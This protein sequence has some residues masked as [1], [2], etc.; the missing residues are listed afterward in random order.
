MPLAAE[1][2]AMFD[3]LAAAGPTPGVRDL[4]LPDARNMYRVARPVNPDLPIHQISDTTMPGP[5]GD[6]ALRIYRPEGTGPFGVLVY[7][8]GGGWVIGDLD[9]A[10]AVCRELATLAGIVVVSVDYRL[11][12]E[13]CYPAAVEDSY[14]ALLWV[15]D[16]AEQLN[17]NG[18]IGVCGESAGANLATVIA[19]QSRDK[20]GPAIAF[21]CLLYPVTD[22]EMSR[23]SYAENG[24]GYLLETATM[25]WFWDTYCPN[26][27]QRLGSDASPLR[28][29]SLENL[30]PALV[31]TAEFD[32][33]RDEGNA[34]AK[35]LEAAGNTATLMCC[36]GLVHDF[37][38]TAAVF[39]CSREPFDK[40][41]AALRAHLHS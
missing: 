36:D 7:F 10:D 1:Y 9:T 8:H 22:A 6:I 19:Q 14:A 33:L 13:H 24:T 5:A 25:E 28:A 35:A 38:S 40:T 27:E 20:N 16:N 17:S 37:F 31:V 15:R 12:P 3:Q 21:Q 26:P 34:Y 11:A 41:V 39:S 29:Q 18:N 2:Q 23:D 32:P 30:P 4:P